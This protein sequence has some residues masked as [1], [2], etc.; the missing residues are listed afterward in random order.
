MIKL[1]RREFMAAVSLLPGLPVLGATPQRRRYDACIP[2]A[3]MTLCTRVYLTGRAVSKSTTMP[4]LQQHKVKVQAYGITIQ[5][6]T[7]GVG[8][9]DIAKL[10]YFES[11][12]VVFDHCESIVIASHVFC[13]ELRGVH[14]RF[15]TPETLE[16]DPISGPWYERRHSKLLFRFYDK[17]HAQPQARTSVPLKGI[18]WPNSP[19]NRKNSS[20]T[21]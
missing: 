12:N 17:W 19:T 5:W 16:T 8:Q 1:S 7:T 14:H 9:L 20:P 21:A 4:T 3:T 18:T 13:M 15:F 11:R 6:P 2:E 10:V